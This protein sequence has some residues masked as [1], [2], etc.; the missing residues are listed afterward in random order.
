M[1]K[2]ILF[3]LAALSM[4]A[5]C[6]NAEDESIRGVWV[7]APK[8]TS[9]LHTYENI[10]SFV[11][12]MDEIG[13]NSIFLVSYA[14]NKTIYRS[15]VLM[16]NSSYT[17]LGQTSMLEQYA[18][19]YSGPSGDPVRD[20]INE[21]HDKGIKVFFWFE[22]GFMGKGRPI[23]ADDPILSVNPSWLGIGNDGRPANYNGSDY[24]YNSYLPDVQDFLINLVKESLELYPDVD[25]VQGDDRLP[26]APRN[27]GYDEY[28]ASLW[29]SAHSGALPPED[30]EN[31]EWVE[32]RLGLLNDFARR[33]H[34]EVKAAAPDAWV[35]FAPNPYPWCEEKLMQDWPQWCAD[36]LCDLLAVQCYRYS[37]EAYRATVE[38]VV[39]HA[40]TANPD[41]RIAPGIILMVGKDIKMTTDV[42]T[43]QI[44]VNRELGLTGEIYFYNEAIRDPE[45]KSCL[46]SV[47]RP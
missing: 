28:T 1:K 10:Q 11:A 27:S 34:S 19:A 7:P 43:R 42:L 2:Y 36:G 14:D 24:Y 41:Q 29:A 37:E 9:V 40:R 17:E 15:R 25:G 35:S 31:E 30:F 46:K 20:L 38:E 3:M 18:A 26:A 23:A 16:D 47:Y 5:S 33:L 21:A 22:Y 44:A 45:I 12:D 8:F 6:G 32:F 13:L 4:L 39:A